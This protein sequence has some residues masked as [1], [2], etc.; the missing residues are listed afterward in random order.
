[1]I[2]KIS[3]LTCL[4]FILPTV[5]YSAGFDCSKAQTN[6][7]KC[8]CANVELSNADTLLSQKYEECMDSLPF[9]DK[10]TLK[11]DQLNWMKQRDK[12][13]KENNESDSFDSLSVCLLNMY[14]QRIKEL[15]ILIAQSSAKMAKDC[16]PPG[17]S[18]K[19]VQ[20]AKDT[21]CDVCN[22]IRALARENLVDDFVNENLEYYEIKDQNKINVKNTVYWRGEIEWLKEFGQGYVFKLH[23]DFKDPSTEFLWFR[24]IKGTASCQ[25][26]DYFSK[27]NEGVY[28]YNPS[29][30]K[31]LPTCGEG[32]CCGNDWHN[33]FQLNGT[34]Y[35]YNYRTFK[36]FSIQ[37][38][39]KEGPVEECQFKISESSI[40][41]LNIDSA[42]NQITKIVLSHI[43]SKLDK[44][45]TSGSW[46][47]EKLYSNFKKINLTSYPFNKDIEHLKS[48]IT[49][50]TI[51]Y[52]NDGETE[53]VCIRDFPARFVGRLV[54]LHKGS[55]GV[56]ENPA[57]AFLDKYPPH[58]SD[59]DC[60]VFFM[61][62]GNKTYT[63]NYSFNTWRTPPV[64]V[65][66]VYLIEGNKTKQIATIR[67]I[68]DR[69]VKMTKGN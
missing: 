13:C 35:S 53:L 58:G 46:N 44:I 15:E 65:C 66:D 51:D 22:F 37:R 1:M 17:T 9:Q 7:E 48:Y 30:Q 60:A 38:I 55:N 24:S 43:V 19:F 23:F 29:L 47:N 32:D 34:L 12:L 54:I 33:F 27:N 50:Y 67:I 11:T 3:F 21:D 49:C 69:D 63:I 26:D 57:S 62:I 59:Y 14:D 18:D 68:L 16:L 36:D 5:I 10:Q 41:Q 8:I 39:T 61:K 45:V 40:K 64:G 42:D 20:L 25:Y 4:M 56:Y 28:E 52:N 2:R 6:I 31:I